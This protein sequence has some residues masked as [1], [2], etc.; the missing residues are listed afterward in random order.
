MAAADRARRQRRD[1]ALPAG[2]EDDAP[3]LARSTHRVDVPVLRVADGAVELD[4][5]RGGERSPK[6]SEAIGEAIGEAI[7]SNRR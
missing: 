4:E 7:E 3:I 2:V 5:L 6:Q 1:P